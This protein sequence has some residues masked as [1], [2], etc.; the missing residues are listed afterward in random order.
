MK[1]LL[2]QCERDAPGLLRDGLPETPEYVPIEI[3]I[4]QRKR[5]LEQIDEINT[6]TGARNPIAA[7]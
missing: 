2:D 5:D 1:T 7:G 3:V 6:R 4:H